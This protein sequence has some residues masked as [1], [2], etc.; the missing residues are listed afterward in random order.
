MY[1]IGRLTVF[2]CTVSGGAET[3]CVE[4]GTEAVRA[5]SGF[6]RLGR[7]TTKSRLLVEEAGEKFGGELDV[8]K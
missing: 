8:R 4:E 6:S 1:E 2:L 5:R 7:S 3:G